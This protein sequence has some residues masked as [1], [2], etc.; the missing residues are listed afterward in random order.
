MFEFV[1]LSAKAE[2]LIL[3]AADLVLQSKKSE[4]LYFAL[5]SHAVLYEVDG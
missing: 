3:N 4:D 2:M 5:Q 1:V